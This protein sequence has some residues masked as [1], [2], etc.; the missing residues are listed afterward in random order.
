MTGMQSFGDP[1]RFEISAQWI[2]DKEHRN[3]LPKA[4][5]WSMGELCIK[6]GGVTLTEHR[7][8]G[9]SKESLQWYLGPL[10]AWLLSQWKWLM[11]E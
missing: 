2:K 11:H 3:R 1:N 9:E 10:V 4:Y 5:G 6:V 8:H 7:I